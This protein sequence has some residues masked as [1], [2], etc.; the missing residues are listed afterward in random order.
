MEIN[1]YERIDAND[2]N[3]QSNASLISYPSLGFII[4]SEQFWNKDNYTGFYWKYQKI[5]FKQFHDNSLKNETVDIA[6]LS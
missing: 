4:G 3:N 1:S 2:V 6:G 5:K